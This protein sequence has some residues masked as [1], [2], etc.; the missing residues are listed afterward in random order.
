MLST[1]KL[2]FWGCLIMSS[3]FLM[4][5]S[6]LFGIILADYRDNRY[7]PCIADCGVFM[8]LMLHIGC[9]VGVSLLRKK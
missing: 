6:F 5:G 2:L 1:W 3:V 4:S 8:L 9:L 7:V